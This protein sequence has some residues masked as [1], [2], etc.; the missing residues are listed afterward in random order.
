MRKIAKR[1]GEYCTSES[2]FTAFQRPPPHEPAAADAEG[3]V[4][5]D[6]GGSSGEM[7]Y[8]PRGLDQNQY[9]GNP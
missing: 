2:R 8:T 9:A 5:H 3:G 1:I 4:G 6:A 7:E